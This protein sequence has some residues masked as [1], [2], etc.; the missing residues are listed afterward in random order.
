MYPSNQC[1][2]DVVV[3]LSLDVIIIW[4]CLYDKSYFRVMEF[5]SVYLGDFVLRHV[6]VFDLLRF[7]SRWHHTSCSSLIRFLCIETFSPFVA[8]DFTLKLKLSQVAV[9]RREH[10]VRHFLTLGTDGV[11]QNHHFCFCQNRSFFYTHR[12]SNSFKINM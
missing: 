5:L 11:Q 3:C 6:P 4:F 10:P 1:Q 8:G 7:P 12:N 9:A 2:I